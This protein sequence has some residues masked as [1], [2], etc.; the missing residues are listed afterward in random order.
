MIINLLCKAF[1]AI[2]DILLLDFYLKNI[3]PDV[4]KRKFKNIK[5]IMYLIIFI[6]LQYIYNFT[7]YFLMQLFI[8]FLLFIIYWYYSINK[9]D[10]AKGILSY[11][12]E[13]IIIQIF[14]AFIL[15][16][17]FNVRFYIFYTP[18]IFN[19]F[20]LNYVFADY[21][22]YTFLL[23]KYRNIIFINLKY[24][25]LLT[26][27][28]LIYFSFV[29]IFNNPILFRTVSIARTYIFTV[30]ISIIAL[31]CFDRMQTKYETDKHNKEAIIQNMAKEEEFVQELEKQQLEIRKINHNLNHILI[32][33]Q[34]H[35]KQGEYKEALE[36]I[37]K[38]LDIHIKAYQALTHT[39]MTMI[40][41]TIN[42][43]IYQM[44]EQNIEYDEEI[45]KI[46]HLGSIVPDDL[47]LVLGLAFDNAREA[48]EKVKDQ[49]KISLKLQSKQT[50]IIIHITNSIPRGSHP[51]FHKTSKKDSVAHG[52][53]VKGIK[54]IAKK[55]HGDVKY[56]VKD[57][58]VVLRIM[59]QK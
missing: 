38:N 43:Q 47:S 39:G 54:E 33:L 10:F 26:I 11:S 7:S 13:K 14:A 27:F 29:F 5:Y 53:G 50:H 24:Y 56:D 25:K 17:I 44:K 57:D 15:T 21:I 19:Y 32:I 58:C 20:I 23:I 52:Y 35:L 8:T 3:Y 59:L 51:Y 45:T 16:W 9:L 6:C 31:I 2:L 40:D 30:V 48:C 37:D 18:K 4:Y 46:L 34:S 28:I 12:F 42:H 49:R 41:S 36:Y 1:I 22:L 55:Y